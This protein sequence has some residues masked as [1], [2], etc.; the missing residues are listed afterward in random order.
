MPKKLLIL[1]FILLFLFA[2]L[3]PAAGKDNR[4][5]GILT[6][7]VNGQL[8]FPEIPFWNRAGGPNT[9]GTVKHKVK[10]GTSVEIVHELLVNNQLW[11]KVNT[12]GIRR[13]INGWVPS[14]VVKSP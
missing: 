1:S 7:F 2:G 11:Y 4:K 13:G 3:N 8:L 12:Y 9:G 5:L 6:G 14:Y 10:S